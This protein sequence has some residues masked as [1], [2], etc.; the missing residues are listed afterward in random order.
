MDKIYKGI[1]NR[2]KIGQQTGKKECLNRQTMMMMATKTTDGCIA[3]CQSWLAD[4]DTLN[5]MLIQALHREILHHCCQ[6]SLP[7]STTYYCS[8]T[9]PLTMHATCNS[10]C[11][12]I[13]QHQATAGRAYEYI[14]QCASNRKQSRVLVAVRILWSPLGL[15]FGGDGEG[16]EG[17]DPAPGT[18]CTKQAAMLPTAAQT[19]VGPCCR[20]LDPVHCMD[21]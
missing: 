14:V 13:L 5:A 2:I 6:L 17:K 8:L 19:E 20:W 10:C 12:T 7:A 21:Q 1:P 4:S 18:G 16:G 11:K 9:Q 3:F 15:S